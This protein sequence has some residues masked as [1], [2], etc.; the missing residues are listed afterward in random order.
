MTESAA[1]RARTILQ[2][3]PIFLDTETTGLT[4][5]AEIVEIGIVNAKG[6]KLLDSLVRP[7]ARI[8]SAA[9]DVHG[10]SN[11]MVAKAP[12]WAEIWPRVEKLLSG[13][14]VG[15]YN[16]D[17]D[18]RMMKQSH[19]QHGLVWQDLGGSAFC[20][21]KLYARFH[22]ESLGLAKAKWHK[23]EKAGQQCGI[24]L[25]NSHRATDDARLASAVF[26]HMAQAGD[27][28]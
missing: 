25:P 4:S 15:I 9:T 2:S 18:L 13:R 8:P 14:S 20:V 10:I 1:Q 27:S 19:E 3:K 16:A 6:R 5:S 24:C 22:A 11:K 12:T 26:R 23:L 21:M 17:F 28:K 7:T